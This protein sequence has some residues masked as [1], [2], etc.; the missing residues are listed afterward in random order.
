VVK[1]ASLIVNQGLENSG[2]L[3]AGIAGST[4]IAS[5]AWDD[6][7]T[8]FAATNTKL[9]DA[10][11]IATFITNITSNTTVGSQTIQWEATL[12]TAQFNGASVKRISL[13][14]G[15]TAVVTTAS[16][17]LYGGVDAQTIAKTSDF[18]LITRLQVQFRST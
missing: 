18:S 3:L 6:N 9:N 17:T 14:H 12:T 1:S 7:T 16:T 4:V 11:A 10:G 13:H 15:A 2:K 5:M 8:G